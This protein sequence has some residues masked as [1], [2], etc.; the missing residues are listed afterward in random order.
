MAD[1]LKRIIQDS[2]E[3][4]VL[5]NVSKKCRKIIMNLCVFVLNSY[6]HI[7]LNS[8]AVMQKYNRNINEVNIN[9]NLFSFVG[10]RT[11]TVFNFI[12][13]SLLVDS[14]NNENAEKFFV[15]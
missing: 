8:L 11:G 5:C 3:D 9:K 10:E 15:C 6:N 14:L 7:L 2:G 4:F 12:F 1:H 13:F